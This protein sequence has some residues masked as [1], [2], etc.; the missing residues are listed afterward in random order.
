MPTLVL[1]QR[2]TDDSN[3]LWSAAVKAGW[4]IERV[5]GFAA[6]GG[7]VD[8]VFYSETLLVDAIAKDLAAAV[9]EPTYDWLPNLPSR[10]RQ[11]DVRL[12]TLGE[13]RGLT[14]PAFVK[15]VDDK[16][17]RA[18]VYQNGSTLQA[19]LSDGLGDELA[20]LVSEV[21]PFELEFRAFVHERVAATVSPYLI[22]GEVAERD[23]FWGAPEG[24]FEEAVD[25]LA[26]FLADAAV[27]LP[28]GVVVDVGRLESG[29]WAVVEANPAWA[30]G[31][32]GCDPYAILEVLRA[33]TVP[34]GALSATLARWDRA[35]HQR[36]DSLGG[37]DQP[38]GT[39]GR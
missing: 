27:E 24:T 29:G 11:R 1:S 6:P 33:S 14:E 23:G 37:P 26:R 25:F 39:H 38:R 34:R 31:I 20:V 10:W 12:S 28:P 7:I 3:A 35:A 15:P 4:D 36:R 16:W 21:A 22:H 8:P 32:C 17:M 13:A 18:A 9:L 19:A 30:S 2:Y 5:R